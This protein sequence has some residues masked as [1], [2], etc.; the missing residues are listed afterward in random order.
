MNSEV[1]E[2]YSLPTKSLHVF[3][4]MKNITTPHSRATQIIQYHKTKYLF[5][6]CCRKCQFLLADHFK[7]RVKKNFGF[8]STQT[9]QSDVFDIFFCVGKT[10]ILKKPQISFLD[11]FLEGMAVKRSSSSLKLFLNKTDWILRSKVCTTA[12]LNKADFFG[13]FLFCYLPW[14]GFQYFFTYNHR[15]FRICPDPFKV[16]TTKFF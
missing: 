10:K 16:T 12:R 4:Y 15:T 5:L 11:F 1:V 14:S 8:S 2:N 6:F 3:S 9:F 7:L 13:K